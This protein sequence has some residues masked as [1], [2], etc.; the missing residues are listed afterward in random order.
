MFRIIIGI[1]ALFITATFLVAAGEHYTM[2][3]QE[4]RVEA[5]TLAVDYCFEAKC[6]AIIA[7]MVFEKYL[8]D[9][10]PIKVVPKPKVEKR[11]TGI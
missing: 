2:N 4:I 6:N 1:C 11:D 3:E 7:A 5:L 8:K 9:G 10:V